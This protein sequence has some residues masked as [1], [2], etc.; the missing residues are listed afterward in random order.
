MPAGVAGVLE[1]RFTPFMGVAGPLAG[2]YFCSRWRLGGSG[3]LVPFVSHIT[4]T[5]RISWLWRQTTLSG[6]PGRRAGNVV[7]AGPMKRPV[8]AHRTTR[9]TPLG[10][11]VQT[12][13]RVIGQQCP[14]VRMVAQLWDWRARR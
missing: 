11:V 9:G 1:A 12:M 3:R 14:D 5:A 13:S 2:A 6:P 8:T 7:R 10:V 4:L